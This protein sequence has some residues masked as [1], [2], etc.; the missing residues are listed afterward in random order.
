MER[1]CRETGLLISEVSKTFCPFDGY[2][3]K[4]ASERKLMRNVFVAIA[5]SIQAILCDQGWHHIQFVD[6]VGDT[7]TAG[8][9]EKRGRLRS[10]KVIASPPGTRS[11]RGV[12][13]TGAGGTDDAS[14]GGHYRQTGQ[15][16]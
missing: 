11:C 5:G 10:G 14:D 4:A 1:G 16:I 13:C 9:V 6:R 15:R 7:P 12:W 3:D 2:T 8:K